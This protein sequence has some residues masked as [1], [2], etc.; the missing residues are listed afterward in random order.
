MESDRLP[1]EMR[2][3]FSGFADSDTPGEVRSVGPVTL[4]PALEDDDVFQSAPGLYGRSAKSFS[5][6]ERIS[7]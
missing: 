5:I 4:F 2:S 6:A 1:N 7:A 3:L